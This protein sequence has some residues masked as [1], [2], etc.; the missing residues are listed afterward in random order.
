[1]E[2]WGLHLFGKF[3]FGLTEAVDCIIINSFFFL[4]MPCEFG[5]G[6]V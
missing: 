1:M 6:D 4:T 3:D 2:F 5:D